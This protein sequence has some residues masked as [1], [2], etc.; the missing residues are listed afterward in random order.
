MFEQR[1]GDPTA[2]EFSIRNVIPRL[3]FR[4]LSVLLA[5]LL[6]AM[7]P[8]FGDIM[9]LFGAFG[10]IPLDFLLPIVLYNVALNPSKRSIIFWGNTLIIGVSLFLVGFGAI[11]SVRQ[12]ILDAKLYSLFANL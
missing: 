10:C 9:A 5:T 11:A 12:I 3:L 7:F 6:A 4:S 1:F 2:G 8:F